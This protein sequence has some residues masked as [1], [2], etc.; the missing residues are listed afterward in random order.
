V[1][2][3]PPAGQDSPDRTPHRGGH[4]CHP[5]RAIAIPNFLEAQTRSKVSRVKADM[6]SVVT[7]LEAYFTDHNAYPP[8]DY[9][10]MPRCRPLR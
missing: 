2:V 9:I 10:I 8:C 3:V 5:G 4:H 7:A 6:R 1:S